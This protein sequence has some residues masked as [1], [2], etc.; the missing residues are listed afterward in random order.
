MGK[1]LDMMIEHERNSRPQP[2]FIIEGRRPTLTRTVAGGIIAGPIGAI[3]GFAWR[4]KSKHN[5]YKA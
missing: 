1:I 5:V 2:E 3:A 4:K